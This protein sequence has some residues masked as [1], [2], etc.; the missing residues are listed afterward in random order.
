MVADFKPA[1]MLADE[2]ALTHK[3]SGF[4]HKL[5]PVKSHWSDHNGSKPQIKPSNDEKGSSPKVDNDKPD[6]EQVRER[7]SVLSLQE[8][9][10]FNVR[11][12]V[13]EKRERITD[14]EN[15]CGFDKLLY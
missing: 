11:L 12:L 1:A 15:S 4:S 10:S 2:Y 6:K 5:Y 14:S 3:K 9:W 8:I 7:T 13:S